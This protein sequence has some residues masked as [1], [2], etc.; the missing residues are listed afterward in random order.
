MKIRKYNNSLTWVLTLCSCDPCETNC[1][2]SAHSSHTTWTYC[3]GTCLLRRIELQ[4]RWN[5]EVHLQYVSKFHGI[6]F[7]NLTENIRGKIPRIVV[8]YWLEILD[9]FFNDSFLNNTIIIFSLFTNHDGS[10]S[11]SSEGFNQPSFQW[12]PQL[13]GKEEYS[14]LDSEHEGNPLVVGCV[15]SIIC[16]FNIIKIN[17]TF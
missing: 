15:R 5:W 16:T 1:S 11:I 4:G 6:F 8:K 2:T 17:Y 7:C 9:K 13:I 3:S 12:F 10:F 14:C